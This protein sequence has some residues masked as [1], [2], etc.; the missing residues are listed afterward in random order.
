MYTE[1][2]Y[3]KYYSQNVVHAPV[4]V[5]SSS[6]II[7]IIIATQQLYYKYY[8]NNQTVQILF[9]DVIFKL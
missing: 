8:Y 4:A 1:K 6:N 3:N 5:F 9:N 2:T 7:I